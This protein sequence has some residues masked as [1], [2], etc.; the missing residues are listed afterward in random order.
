MCL[1]LNKTKTILLVSFLLFFIGAIPGV[2]YKINNEKKSHTVEFSIDYMSLMEL[3]NQYKDPDKNLNDMLLRLKK[4]G[5]SSV[6]IP[7]N[8][9]DMMKS[10]GLVSVMTGSELSNIHI[11]SN[12]EIKIDN[13]LT[14][15]T[16]LDKKNKTEIKSIIK[17]S[18]E[19]NY[20]TEQN[21]NGNTIIGLN[22][23]ISKVL[24]V[25]I[26]FLSEDINH[27]TNKPYNFPLIL[28][29]DNKW[30][31]KENSLINQLEKI[32][33]NKISKIY[34]SDNGVIG[35]PKTHDFWMNKLPDVP[36]SYKE[37]FSKEEKQKGILDLAESKDMNIVRL[38]VISS[39]IILKS[40]EEKNNEVEE[41]ILRAV[42]ERNI[43]TFHIQL[44]TYSDEYTTTELFDDSLTL[45]NK[46]VKELKENEF[47]MGISKSLKYK[48]EMIH[49]LSMASAALAGITLICVVICDILPKY[50]NTILISLLYI[51]LCYF[52]V[53]D[54]PIQILG[55][56]IAIF[57]PVFSYLIMIPILNRFN[58]LNMLKSLFVFLTTSI[59]TL[60]L[61]FIIASLFS[62]PVYSLYLKQFRGVSIAHLIPPFIILF[63]MIKDYRKNE[64]ESPFKLLLEPIK[65][66]HIILIAILGIIGLYYLTR[67]GNSGTLLP[68]EMDF[69]NTL[70]NIFGVRPRTKEFLIA[71][72]LMIIVIYYWKKIDWIKWLLPLSFIGQL[73]IVNTFTHFH[74]PFMISLYRASY[75]MLLGCLFGFLFILLI[76]FLFFKK[77]K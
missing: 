26:P 4:I 44:P 19:D 47:S 52:T 17:D 12:K 48:N 73:S 31:G 45:L 71:H 70:E 74:T 41:R 35:Y 1:L 22:V 54:Q 51:F 49:Y 68:F 43:R 30:K 8:T 7:N 24:Y 56:L 5:V 75:G 55:L 36:F 72:P 14:Y 23:P 18:F 37:F 62:E 53:G 25:S 34:F 10:R 32:N 60:S 21:V 20:I 77:R 15:I 67:T 42:K 40:L 46:T 38:H 3:S 11:L 66:I 58:E 33:E 13:K 63:I 39:D 2:L 76:N 27:L 59:L 65:V 16:I 57:I 6:T 61:T 69:R 9:F 29:V 28:K 64:D 50:L